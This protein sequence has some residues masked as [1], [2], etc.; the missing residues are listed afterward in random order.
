MLAIS[1]KLS[2]TIGEDPS[3]K[4]NNT[5]LYVVTRKFNLNT[6]TGKFQRLSNALQWHPPMS[7]QGSSAQFKY[8]ITQTALLKPS[9]SYNKTKREMEGKKLV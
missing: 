4:I 6:K 1:L 2:W 3:Q 9:G 7:T 8:M 5:K